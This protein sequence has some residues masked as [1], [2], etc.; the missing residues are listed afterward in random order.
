LLPQRPQPGIKYGNDVPL[1]L[2]V[3]T[4]DLPIAIPIYPCR[5]FPLLLAGFAPS[6][7]LIAIIGQQVDAETS[8]LSEQN[9]M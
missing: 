8:A 4:I 3:I 9:G 5:I 6:P 2:S 1:K 7:K